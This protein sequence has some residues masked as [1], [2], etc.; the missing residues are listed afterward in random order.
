MSEWLRGWVPIVRCDN[1]ME[2][3]FVSREIH[4]DA[5][6][7][8]PVVISEKMQDAVLSE[9]MYRGGGFVGYRWQVVGGHPYDYPEGTVTA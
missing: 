5:W 7:K 2:R 4:R 1:G 6:A 3:G 9:S 8:N